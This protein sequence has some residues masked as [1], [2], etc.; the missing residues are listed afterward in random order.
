MWN[1]WLHKIL[2]LLQTHIWM[3]MQGDSSSALIQ[4]NDA[5]TVDFLAFTFCYNGFFNP[6]LGWGPLLVRDNM[7]LVF[8]GLIN[9]LYVVSLDVDFY[10]LNMQ[11][12]LYVC[13]IFQGCSYAEHKL[14]LLNFGSSCCRSISEQFF[15]LLHNRNCDLSNKKISIRKKK[16]RSGL[17]LPSL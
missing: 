6:L 13:H 10:H 8:T 3:K 15:L 9:G 2:Q 4:R 14:S 5:L 7:L 16:N 17:N 1:S 11:C 12:T